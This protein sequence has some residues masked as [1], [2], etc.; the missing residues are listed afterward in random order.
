MRLT[1]RYEVIPNTLVS[2]VV[3][4]PRDKNCGSNRKAKRLPWI[5]AA[6]AGAQMKRFPGP[7]LGELL[8]LNFYSLASSEETFFPP[9]YT[10]R[11][12]YQYRMCVIELFFQW[13]PSRV[14]LLPRLWTTLK[15][16]NS[17]FSSLLPRKYYVGKRTK[18]RVIR[19]YTQV[20]FSQLSRFLFRVGRSPHHVTTTNRDASSA[21][22]NFFHLRNRMGFPFIL[23]N[24]T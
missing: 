24:L 23:E 20:S 12:H 11:G 3:R 15:L 14:S 9:K 7:Q 18:I 6:W 22:A 4:M 10:Q 19:R 1:A 5:G 13:N 8:Q 16:I 17:S 2:D 21:S